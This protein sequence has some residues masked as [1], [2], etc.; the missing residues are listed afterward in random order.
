MSHTPKVVGLIPQSGH[1]QKSS[2]EYINKWNNRS[3]FFSSQS[4]KKKK[5]KVV[6]GHTA[7][8]GECVRSKTLGKMGVPLGGSH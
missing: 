6:Q 8:S 7:I 1:T 3:V 4:I 2:S 5:K